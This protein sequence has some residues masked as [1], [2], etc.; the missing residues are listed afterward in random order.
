[1]RLM[2][3]DLEGLRIARH[4][5]MGLHEVERCR[6]RPDD[7]GRIAVHNP[8]ICM[9]YEASAHGIALREVALGPACGQQTG[10]TETRP[11]TPIKG[12]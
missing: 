3:K 8:W 6:T 7:D 10:P 1:M 4:S 12:R 5:A 2:R 11:V 9:R